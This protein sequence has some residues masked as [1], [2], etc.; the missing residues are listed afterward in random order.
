MHRTFIW[1]HRG[2]GFTGVQNTL[3]S[4]ENAIGMGVDGLKTEAKLSKDEEIIL[5]FYESLKRNGN[6]VLM[7]ELIIDEIKEFKFENGETIPTLREV[8]KEFKKYDIRYHIDITEPE[9]GIKIIELAE[10]FNLINKLEI[11]KPS[12]Y[13]HPLPTIFS[14]IREFDQDVTL[15]NSIFLKYSNIKEEHLEL[16]N[17]RKLNIQGINVNFNYANYDLFRKVKDLGFK[18]YIWGILFERSIKNFL[19]MK[20]NGEYVDA[21][22]SNLPERVI[23]MRDDIQT[24]LIYKSNV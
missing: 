10:E 1:G 17:M 6:D 19:S 2:S 4:F 9:V 18:F 15:V 16:E 13:P 11:A 8:F 12:L 24:E 21:I 5:S 20:Y 7:S 23:K 14:K 22:F 3:S